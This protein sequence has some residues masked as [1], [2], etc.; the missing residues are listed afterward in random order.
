MRVGLPRAV[1]GCLQGPVTKKVS[2][3]SSL[4]EMMVQQEEQNMTRVKIR[5]TEEERTRMGRRRLAVDCGNK[6]DARWAV[7]PQRWGA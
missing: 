7:D 2:S 6:E 5:M 1:S 3:S 4:E